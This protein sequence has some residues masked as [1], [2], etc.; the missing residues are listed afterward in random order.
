MNSLRGKKYTYYHQQETKLAMHLETPL[1]A[2][3]SSALHAV[4]GKYHSEAFKQIRVMT[5]FL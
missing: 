3:A 1:R 2:V 5:F 4:I